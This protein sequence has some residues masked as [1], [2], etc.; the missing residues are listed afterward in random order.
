MPNNNFK[1]VP[2]LIILKNR[3]QS[4]PNHSPTSSIQ[5]NRNDGTITSLLTKH[6]HLPSTSSNVANQHN[7]Q[8]YYISKSRYLLFS[9]ELETID[10]PE[11]NQ[12]DNMDLE[13]DHN[14]T[15][16]IANKPPPPI[17]FRT[18]TNFN[19]FCINIKEITKGEHELVLM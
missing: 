2:L 19:S 7:K 3:I 14:E 6:L 4:V 5:S 13:T 18:V 1:T 11:G 15:A 8:K 17:F 16:P 12:S 9:N 10:D